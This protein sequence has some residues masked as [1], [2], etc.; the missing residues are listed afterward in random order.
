MNPNNPYLEI[1]ALANQGAGLCL[2]LADLARKAESG[3][4]D[5]AELLEALAYAGEYFRGA[6]KPLK[7]NHRIYPKAGARNLSD[8]LDRLD[9]SSEFS[10]NSLPYA[11][12]MLDS[13]FPELAFWDNCFPD[14]NSSGQAYV[15]NGASGVWADS[16]FWNPAESG[17]HFFYELNFDRVIESEYMMNCIRLAGWEIEPISVEIEPMRIPAP[18]PASS[19]A[20][21]GDMLFNDRLFRIA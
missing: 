1:S 8:I 9:L 20:F 10:E 21:S 2:A 18:A 14:M 19:P 7:G 13:F 3:N 6:F 15:R 5:D 17:P 11:H 16:H 4:A 12:P